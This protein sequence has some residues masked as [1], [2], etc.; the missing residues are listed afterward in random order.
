MLKAEEE[1]KKNYLNQKSENTKLQGQ[2]TTL[3]TEKTNLQQHLLDLQR[4]TA[5]LELLMG[6]DV[7][8]Q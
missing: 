7:D 4:R 5:E 8:G 6:A 2:I 3:K 1:M